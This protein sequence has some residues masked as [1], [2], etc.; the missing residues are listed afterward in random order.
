MPSLDDFFAALCRRMGWEPTNWRINVLK[1]MAR[2]EGYPSVIRLEQ[3]WNPLDTMHPAG[4]V[5]NWNKAGVKIYPDLATGVEATARTLEQSNFSNLRETLRSQRVNEGT[6]AD[7]RLWGWNSPNLLNTILGAMGGAA[8][9]EGITVASVQA[10]GGTM[11]GQTTSAIWAQQAQEEWDSMKAKA[12]EQ[13]MPISAVLDFYG[14]PPIGNEQAYVTYRSAQLQQEYSVGGAGTRPSPSPEEMAQWQSEFDL[15]LAKAQA[16]WD[17]YGAE[18]AT[19]NFVNAISQA[20][21]TRAAAEYAQDYARNIVP[22]G[23]T[24]L[25]G[26]GPEGGRAELF[27]EVGWEPGPT[28]PLPSAPAPGPYQGLQQAGQYVPQAPE[29]QFTPP[30]LPG[31]GGGGQYAQGGA[32]LPLNT[33]QDMSAY[34]QMLAQA[35]R[36]V[37][38]ADMPILAQGLGAPALGANA[39][40]ITQ[41]LGLARR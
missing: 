1:T 32:G 38:G 29:L 23:V 37:V 14:L 22:P 6:A 16:D 20:Q 35:L 24:T 33:G 13:G 25:P 17:R 8:G 10:G 9:A 12:D 40:I 26:W 5:G 30:T 28:L 11:P 31:G 27:R 3:T 39:P 15:M 19:Q 21:E 18:V 2:M 7:L 36:N 4:A 34:A 41:G